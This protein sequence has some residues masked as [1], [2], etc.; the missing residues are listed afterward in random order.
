MIEV[1]WRLARVVVENLDACQCIQLYDR[2]T[3][4]FYIDPPYWKTAGYRTPFKKGDYI[5]LRQ[6][7]DQVAG[8]FVLSLND[9]PQVRKIFKGFRIRKV[10]TGYSANNGRVA[11]SSRSQARPELLIH[12]L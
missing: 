9:T 4:F 2:P 1:H 6:A 3:T 8:R 5:R 11:G 7:L 12:N 10:V